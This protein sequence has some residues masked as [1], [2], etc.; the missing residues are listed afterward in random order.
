[1]QLGQTHYSTMLF[2]YF[3]SPAV[4]KTMKDP[5]IASAMKEAILTAERA[6]LYALGFQFTIDHP[7]VFIRD[8][9]DRFSALPDPEGEYWRHFKKEKVWWPYSIGGRLRELH[10]AHARVLL[11][12]LISHSRALWLH[13]SHKGNLEKQ[14][15]SGACWGAAD[16]SAAELH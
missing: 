13:R 10:T 16:A 2:R 4:L 8:T 5:E 7:Q 9:L 1:M 3:N 14:L 6:L 11:H 15:M 12:C